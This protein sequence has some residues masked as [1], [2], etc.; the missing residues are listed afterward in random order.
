MVYFLV[1]QDLVVQPITAL[2]VIIILV[3]L[4]MLKVAHDEIDDHM[5]GL[6]TPNEAFFH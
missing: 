1:P 4:G 2:F 3:N 5:H 6:K